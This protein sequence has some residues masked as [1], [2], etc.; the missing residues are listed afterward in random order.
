[1]KQYVHTVHDIEPAYVTGEGMDEME[2][3]EAESNM[4][5]LVSE[6]QQYQDASAEEE[7]ARPAAFDGPTG[8][9]L[10]DVRRHFASRGEASASDLVFNG[11]LQVSLMRRRRLPKQLPQGPGSQAGDAPRGRGPG[12]PC[13]S[14]GR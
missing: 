14:Q 4:N 12:A 10:H 7:G 3:T 2:F 11:V 8:L 6:Y 1:M 9:G 13:A 5:D